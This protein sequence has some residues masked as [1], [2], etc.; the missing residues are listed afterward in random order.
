MCGSPPAVPPEPAEQFPSFVF[1]IIS[2][3][4]CCSPPRQSRYLRF[5]RNPIRPRSFLLPPPSH[6]SP[7]SEDTPLLPPKAFFPA[8]LFPDPYFYS[9]LLL[10]PRAAM[11]PESS[12]SLLHS[13]FQ[14]PTSIA[15]YFYT[16][17]LRYP[18]NLSLQHRFF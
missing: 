2:Q 7:Y 17:P 9:P 10:Y 14:T 15:R 12:L 1:K 3:T 6:S 11:S 13:L 4:L 5:L 18:R 16:P 8:Q